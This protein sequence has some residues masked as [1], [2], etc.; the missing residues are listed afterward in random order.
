MLVHSRQYMPSTRH[1]QRE[2]AWT[3]R[4]RGGREIGSAAGRTRT[5]NLLI[6]SQTLCPFELRPHGL[7]AG[8]SAPRSRRRMLPSNDSG[9]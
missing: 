4:R 6:R 3:S 5:P 9:R 8:N 1:R 2:D 7:F